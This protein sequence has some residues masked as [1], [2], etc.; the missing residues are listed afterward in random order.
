MKK[1]IDILK[2][3]KLF[4]GVGE[5][6]MES[7]MN[8]M[9]AQVRQYDKG[10]YIFR[11]GEY[12]ENICVVISGTVHIQS[13]DYWGNRSITSEISA[14]EMFGE[15]YAV[16]SDTAVL[17]DAVTV[18]PC[19]VVFFNINKLMTVCKSACI[20]H[21]LVI[22]NLMTVLAHK[23]RQLIQKLTHMSKR[24]TREKLISYLSY[25]SRLNCSNHFSIPFNRQQ[26]A[27]FL[28]VDRSAMS[29][30]LCKMRDDGLIRFDKNNFTLL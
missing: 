16:H 6:D 17:N 15:A 13:D 22:Q 28:S 8:C 2:H 12:I 26:L 29:N 30:E 20:F 5:N 7:M 1:Y 25:Q 24:T 3:T 27:D 9:D 18:T 10:E 23:N 11:Q 14:G 4:L 21:S 19:T